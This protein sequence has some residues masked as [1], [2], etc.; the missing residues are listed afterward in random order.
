M[1]KSNTR[2]ISGAFAG[3]FVSLSLHPVDTLKT[4]IQSC[5]VD[6]KSM[7]Y[8][9]LTGLYRGIGSDIVSS[10]PIS[11][12]YTFSYES[13]KG[14]LLPLFPK[15]HSLAHCMS[16]GSVSVAISIIFTPRERIKQQVKKPLVGIMRK[17]GL[18]SLYTGWGAVLCRNVPHS[19]IEVLS[20]Y[21]N[22][23]ACHHHSRKGIP[24]SRDVASSRRE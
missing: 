23:V 16:G 6:H 19:I 9:G 7:F 22:C 18:S 21:S 2:T 20:F 3:I 4:L 14:T 17:G 8:I 24:M 15:Y 11:A 10:A 1:P 5:L 13:V 12:L